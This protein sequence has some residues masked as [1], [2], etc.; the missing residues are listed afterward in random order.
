MTKFIVMTRFNLVTLQ[1]A[2]KLNIVF[3]KNAATV[4]KVILAL[5]PWTARQY[6]GSIPMIS[7]LN[8][9][10]LTFLNV[11]TDFNSIFCQC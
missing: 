10:E 1:A 8:I 9:Q 4:I 7:L 5:V 6:V 3:W 11:I 2:A